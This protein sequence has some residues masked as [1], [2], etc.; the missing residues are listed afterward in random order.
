MSTL[1]FNLY[2]TRLKAKVPVMM[3][4]STQEFYPA[5]EMFV[6]RDGKNPVLYTLEEYGIHA[7]KTIQIPASALFTMFD[8]MDGNGKKQSFKEADDAE[9]E[10]DE[11]KGKIPT[12]IKHFK[13]RFE[14]TKNMD[15][16]LDGKGAIYFIKKYPNIGTICVITAIWRYENKDYDAVILGFWHPGKKLFSALDN[17]VILMMKQANSPKITSQWARN[18]AKSL[19]GV[20]NNKSNDFDDFRDAFDSLKNQYNP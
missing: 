16:L 20:A 13:W 9:D 11:T 3:P 5:G 17:H 7:T 14:G 10:P 1:P 15:K 2:G 19:L 12:H 6:L 4:Y 8:P 18:E